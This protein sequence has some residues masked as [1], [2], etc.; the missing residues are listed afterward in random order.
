MKVPI[1]LDPVVVKL[2]LVSPPSYCKLVSF[3]ERCLKG[4][5]VF[6]EMRT[7]GRSELHHLD[8]SRLLMVL[9]VEVARVERQNLYRL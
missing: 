5:I 4:W 2:E 1:T 6:F 8:M 7:I 3:R 9:E